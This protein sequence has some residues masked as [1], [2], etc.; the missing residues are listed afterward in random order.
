MDFKKTLLIACLF[1][2]FSSFAQKRLEFNEII[3]FSGDNG[4]YQYSIL[5]TVPTGKAIKITTFNFVGSCSIFINK[6]TISQYASSVTNNLPI[7]LKEGDVFGIKNHSNTNTYYQL[8]GI[9]F[10]IVQ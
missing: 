7:W 6:T 5:D 3:S 8:S 10:N 1:A 2:G 4:I 9:E